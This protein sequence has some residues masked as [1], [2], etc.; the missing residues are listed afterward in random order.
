MNRVQSLD[1]AA[2]DLTD[3]LDMQENYGCDP[4]VVPMAKDHIK[5]IHK[6]KFAT[7]AMDWCNGAKARQYFWVLENAFET[8]YP[9]SCLCIP[10]NCI[11]PGTDSVYKNYYDRGIYKDVQATIPCAI[12][13]PNVH[14]GPIHQVCCCMD[15]CECWNQC[16]SCYWPSCCG[17]RISIVPAERCCVL[18]PMRACWVHNF[19]S[20]CGPKNGEPTLYLPFA[21]HLLRGE[22]VKL[23]H[24]LD[25][26]RME[27]RERTGK[28]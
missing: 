28:A 7:L 12:G 16:A 6:G 2:I 8:N 1:A 11:C 18:C 24:Q 4:A 20:L 3:A 22:A 19:F 23:A 17:E 5:I 25:K 26:A 10:P 9:S 21:T 13:E 14:A 27:F 15:C